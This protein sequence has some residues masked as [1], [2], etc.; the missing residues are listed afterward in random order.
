MEVQGLE[1]PPLLL[2]GDEIDRGDGPAREEESVEEDRAE[3]VARER[4]TMYVAMTRAMRALLVVVPPS[5]TSPLLTG[6]S[7]ERWNRGAGTKL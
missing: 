5:T 1:G 7:A 4:R 2:A 3:L 6:F